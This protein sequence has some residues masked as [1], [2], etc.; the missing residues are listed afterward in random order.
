MTSTSHAPSPEGYYVKLAV[1]FAT[2]TIAVASAPVI[3]VVGAVIAVAL[4]YLA[5]RS[6]NEL[7]GS[8][9]IA[10]PTT[11]GV[12]WLGLACLLV[13]AG[14]GAASLTDN[15]AVAVVAALVILGAVPALGAQFDRANLA[16]A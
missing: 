4:V 11:P 15:V 12:H 14:I 2:L 13:V 10:G 6:W 7:H 3:Q 8:F 16:G 9:A 5:V 1:A